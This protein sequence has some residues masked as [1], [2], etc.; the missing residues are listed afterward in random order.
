M[1]LVAFDVDMLHLHIGDFAPG[2]IFPT[3]QP[4]GYFQSFCR[5]R[6]GYKLDDRFVIAQRLSAPIRRN[7]GKEPV[8]DLVPF[9]RTW[10]KMTD[11]QAKAGL[12]RKLLQFQFPKPQPPAVTATAVGRDQEPA[13][14]RIKPPAFMA[15]PPA[16]R[17]NREG[18]GVMIG[19]DNDKA[20]IVADVVDAIGVGARY[21]GAGEVVTL[22]LL[23]L[24]G[25]KPLLA[26]VVEVS[27]EF[28]FL[29]VHRDHR[30]AKRQPSFHFTVDMSKLRIAIRVVFAFLGLAIALKTVVEIV[31]NLGHLRMA[32]RVILSAQLIRNRP[33]TLADPSQWRLRVAPRLLVYHF[34][35]G[36]HQVRIGHRN[37][38]ASGSRLTD[39]P[40][41]GKGTGFN[42]LIFS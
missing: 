33:R 21:V 32:D 24:F 12:I 20:A 41:P 23:G 4:A 17:S 25:R 39:A 19:S 31:K 3:I 22:N 36:F 13:C 28:F 42:F 18:S 30:K 14:L 2:R 34:F 6:L 8:F 1:K 16:D 5:G 26:G 11:G 38:L 7:K 27:D 15:P 29:G 37:R 35:Q 40:L 9:A 10:R